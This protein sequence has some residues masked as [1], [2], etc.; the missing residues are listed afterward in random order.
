MQVRNDALGLTPNLDLK[1]SS[2]EE[3][4][5]SLG[6]APVGNYTHGSN[7]V[8]FLAGNVLTLAVTSGYTWVSLYLL[9]DYIS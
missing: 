6:R 5:T 2:G 1:S 8:C 7:H 9:D 3:S 4:T